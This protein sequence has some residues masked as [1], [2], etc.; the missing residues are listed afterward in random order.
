MDFSEF[1]NGGGSQLLLDEKEV[2]LDE[3]FDTV[4]QS[5]LSVQEIQQLISQ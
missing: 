5:V 2:L 1:G 4:E 3:V